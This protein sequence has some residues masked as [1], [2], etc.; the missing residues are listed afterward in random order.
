MTSCACA[1]VSDFKYKVV[2]MFQMNMITLSKFSE[3][4]PSLSEDINNM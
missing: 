4:I 2:K 3:N 1:N